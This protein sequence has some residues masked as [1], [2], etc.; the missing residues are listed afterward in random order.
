LYFSCKN[1]QELA[2]GRITTVVGYFTMNPTKFVLHFS[3]VSTI[4]Y[5][6][7]KKQKNHFTIGV[8]LSQ[9]GP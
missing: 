3:D 2:Q 5:G 6:V 4:F 8:T 7:Y 1:Y 9:L